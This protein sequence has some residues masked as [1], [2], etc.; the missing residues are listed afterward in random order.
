MSRVSLAERAKLSALL[1]RGGLRRL[2]NR[3]TGI[4]SFAGV[5]FRAKPTV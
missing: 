3:L 4:R 2:G 5:S 1:L